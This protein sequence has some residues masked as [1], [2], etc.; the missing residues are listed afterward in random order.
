[1]CGIIQGKETM[2]FTECIEGII[3][4]KDLQGDDTYEKQTP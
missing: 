1:M 3:K 4:R 2:K